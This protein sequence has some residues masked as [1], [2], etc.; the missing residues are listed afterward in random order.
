VGSCPNCQAPLAGPSCAR[1]GYLVAA[2][3][4]SA[5]DPR[6]FREQ[7]TATG[8]HFGA[9]PGLIPGIVL[10]GVTGLLAGVSV[11]LSF[12]DGASGAWI[13]PL[14]VGALLSSLGLF[15]FFA[16]SELTIGRD[17]VTVKGGT[18]PGRYPRESVADVGWHKEPT[19]SGYIY[20]LTLALRD[21]TTIKLPFAFG[22]EGNAAY[23]VGR[24]RAALNA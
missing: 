23:A 10:F 16:K 3:P 22:L 12:A 6:D 18:G 13:A 2:A 1:C 11:F 5:P 9:R 19:R 15:L 20:G 21:G 4:A 8:V 7:T 17:V 14:G 24:V